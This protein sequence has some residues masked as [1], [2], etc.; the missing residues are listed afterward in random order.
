MRRSFLLAIALTLCAAFTCFAQSQS[1]SSSPQQ[2][3]PAAQQPAQV[4]PSSSPAP[5][6]SSAGSP[7]DSA[8]PKR[9]WTD[10]DFSHARKLPGTANSKPFSKPQPGAKP[11]DA[12]YISKTKK[13][14]EK[15]QADISDLD[16]QIDQLR[17]FNEG[18]TVGSSG[19]VK[20][21]KSFSRDPI[22]VQIQ[23]LQDKKKQLED[24][25][26]ALLDEA[27]KKGVEPGQLR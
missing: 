8:K 12:A 27:R 22:P 10:D 15:L 2:N 21:T 14:L 16:K 26:D 13:Q 6:S 1:T 3:P 5:A 11:A 9:V 19:A 4:D 7:S 18:E 25:I 20:L 17:R 24:Q 23:E